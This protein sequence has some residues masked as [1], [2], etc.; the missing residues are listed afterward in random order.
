[1]TGAPAAPLVPR[2]LLAGIAIVLVGIVLLADSLGMLDA[3]SG[4][5]LWPIAVIIAGIAVRLQPGIADRVAGAVV[6]FAGL[7]LFFN[8]LGIWTYPFW[9]IWPLI[10]ILIGAW[11]WY[12]TWHLRRV[13]GTDQ[14]GAV[15]LLSEVADRADGPLRSVELAAIAGGCTFDVGDA[16][17]GRDP[18]IV[19]AFVVAGRVRVAVPGDWVVS[20]RVLSLPGNVV[21]A[22]HQPPGGADRPVDL[23]V[24]GTAIVGV[25][26]VIASTTT[27]ARAAVGVS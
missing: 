18:I 9:R 7:W 2:G 11:M 19:D 23:I 1:M 25:V 10:L 20:L 21:D 16:V 3:R 17:R 8:A 5:D 4:W 24:R 26:Q 13:S 27:T 14:P 6:L 15:A 12:R 22:R